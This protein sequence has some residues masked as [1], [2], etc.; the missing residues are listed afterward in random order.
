MHCF[1]NNFGVL[2]NSIRVGM[3][4]KEV[5]TTPWQAERLPEMPL[6]AD[7]NNQIPVMIGR[8]SVAVFNFLLY[9]KLN[10]IFDIFASTDYVTTQ[11]FHPF[12]F[13]RVS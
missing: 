4:H 6:R 3:G 2:C 13:G 8:R 9:S 12:L 11:V 7:G 5:F 1:L 10:Q